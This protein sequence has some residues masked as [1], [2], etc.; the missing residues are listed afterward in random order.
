MHSMGNVPQIWPW[1]E[2]SWGQNYSI[3]LG[4]RVLVSVQGVEPRF[5]DL[6][7]RTICCTTF[8]LPPGNT[9]WLLAFWYEIT[10]SKLFLGWLGDYSIWLINTPHDQF[11]AMYTLHLV[12]PFGNGLGYFWISHRSLWNSSPLQLIHS[13]VRASSSF[14]TILNG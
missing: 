13:S 3:T 7:L 10:D 5:L 8:P 4:R 6:V 2:P 9:F 12:I 11:F 14:L 1:E